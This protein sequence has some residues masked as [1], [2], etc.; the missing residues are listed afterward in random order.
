MNDKVYEDML[1]EL[2]EAKALIAR[3]EQGHKETGK[4]LSE[5]IAWN[6]QYKK[7]LED[8][9]VRGFCTCKKVA[10]IALTN[11]PRVP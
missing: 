7:A 11:E 9:K 10:E 5:L 6:S 2:S 8:I 1:D 3:Y 4:K